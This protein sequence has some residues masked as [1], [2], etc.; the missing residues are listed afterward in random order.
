MILC[1]CGNKTLLKP[2]TFDLMQ[3]CMLVRNTHLC[4]YKLRLLISHASC[5]KSKFLVLKEFSPNIDVKNN[6]KKQFFF[7]Y[8]T[9]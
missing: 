3:R 8:S 4:K 1:D 2:A 7:E 5:L 9:C 6:F